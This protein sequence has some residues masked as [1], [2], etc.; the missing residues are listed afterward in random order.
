MIKNFICLRC[1]GQFSAVEASN[2]VCPY[3]KSDNIRI[4]KQSGSKYVISVL[5]FVVFL[6]AG[7]FFPMDLILKDKASANIQLQTP[8]QPTQT[9]QQA[10]AVAE[11]AAQEPVVSTVPKITSVSEPVLKNGKYEFDVSAQVDKGK[12]TYEVRKEPGYDLVQTNNSGKFTGIPYSES[13]LYRV[14]VINSSSP[15]D[16]DYQIV[17][18]FEKPVVEIPSIKKV[19]KE[20]IEQMIN[21]KDVNSLK[22]CSK[23]ARIIIANPEEA[24]QKPADYNGVI[25]NLKM[26]VWKGVVVES[27]SYNAQNYVISVKIRVIPK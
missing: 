4:F 6:A 7:F 1:N 26:G 21:S 8:A 2:T 3:C 20:E 25:L 24:V 23:N 10:S 5:C 27:A 19:S 11:L 22:Q 13:G 14:E 12:L 16:K 17:A 9:M 18:G 15:N